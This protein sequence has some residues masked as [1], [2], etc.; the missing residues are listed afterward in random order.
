MNIML[1]DTVFCAILILVN[2]IRF[3]GFFLNC[4]PMTG[5]AN[6]SVTQNICSSGNFLLAG[7]F[8][9]INISLEGKSCWEKDNSGCLLGFGVQNSYNSGDKYCELSRFYLNLTFPMLVNLHLSKVIKSG[10]SKVTLQ[11]MTKS[12]ETS[13]LFV[14]TRADKQYCYMQLENFSQQCALSLVTSRSLDI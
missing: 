14:Q 1:L 11:I 10:R 7:R 13:Y 2:T 12:Y 9:K 8:G 3:V 5:A 4:Q 6:G